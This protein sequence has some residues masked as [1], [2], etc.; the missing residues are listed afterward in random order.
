MASVPPCGFK[1]LGR[2]AI[3]FATEQ[4]KNFLRLGI[5]FVLIVEIASIFIRDLPN[6]ACFWYPLLTHTV[7]LIMVFSVFLW[8]ERLR[9]CFRKKFA[10]VFLCLYYALGVLAL[11]ANFSTQLSVDVVS[12]FLLGLAVIFFLL[13]FFQTNE[14]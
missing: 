9:F 13:S 10:S 8:R 14:Y 4:R 2:K 11:V 5:F 12:F 1:C 7:L 6:Y 3:D